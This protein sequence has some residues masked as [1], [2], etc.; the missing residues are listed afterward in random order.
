MKNTRLQRYNCRMM[1]KKLYQTGEKYAFLGEGYDFLHCNHCI[2][3]QAE[4]KL[5]S[6]SHKPH[7]LTTEQRC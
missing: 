1:H 4:L 3:P 2:Q 6:A 5:D 7:I